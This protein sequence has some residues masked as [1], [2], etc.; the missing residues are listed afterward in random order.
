MVFFK[1]ATLIIPSPTVVDVLSMPVFLRKALLN[2]G[3]NEFEVKAKL[4]TI[5]ELL[6]AL[7]YLPG[8]APGPGIGI[9]IL[10]R[11]LLVTELNDKALVDK[12]LVERGA[13]ISLS[14]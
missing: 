2:I 5:D 4:E 14:F 8:T 1:E 12:D 11:E 6:L 10:L 13:G 7:L 9:L 3:A